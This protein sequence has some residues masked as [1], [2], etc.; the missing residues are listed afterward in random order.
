MPVRVVFK[1]GGILQK[2]EFVAKEYG[3]KHC[4]EYHITQMIFRKGVAAPILP[5]WCRNNASKAIL[6]VDVGIVH[7]K[8]CQSANRIGGEKGCEATRS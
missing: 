2:I 8:R 6:A 7:A 4:E 5:N 1:S 3:N